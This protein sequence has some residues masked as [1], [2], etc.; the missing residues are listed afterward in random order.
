MQLEI[1]VSYGNVKMGA[2]FYKE[3]IPKVILDIRDGK[4]LYEIMDEALE[5]E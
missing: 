5:L 1:N 4:S 2:T 3:A